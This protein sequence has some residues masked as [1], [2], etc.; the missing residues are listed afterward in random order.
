MRH[1]RTVSAVGAPDSISSPSRA[2]KSNQKEQKKDTKRSVPPVV[3][4]CCVVCPHPFGRCDFFPL[5]KRRRKKPPADCDCLSCP[6]DLFW[7]CLLFGGARSFFFSFLF[8][9]A[10]VFPFVCA[11]DDDPSVDFQPPTSQ[12]TKNRF[13]LVFLSERRV[14]GSRETLRGPLSTRRLPRLR[15]VGYLVIYRD[16]DLSDSDCTDYCPCPL[17]VSLHILAQKCRRSGLIKASRQGSLWAL[18]FIA[19]ILERNR[20]MSMDQ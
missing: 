10:G 19:I 11:R 3:G 4:R 1:F 6:L 20:I 2:V 5:K 16:D 12:L 9:F 15:C 8:F 7:F 18:S 14:G 17:V 13:F